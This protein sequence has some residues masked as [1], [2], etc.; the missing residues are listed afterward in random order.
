MLKRS[1]SFI[2]LVSFIMSMMI[3]SGVFFLGAYVLYFSDASVM[4][5]LIA[6]GV[7][8]V[9]S[10]LLALNFVELGMMFPQ[11]GGTY[12]FLK[13]AYSQ[14]LASIFGYTGFL[15]SGSGSIA[16]L[17]LAFASFIRQINPTL[18]TPPTLL[19]SI[20]IIT[21]TGLAMKN[22][23]QNAWVG[24]VITAAKVLGI[25]AVIVAGLSMGDVDVSLTIPQ[26]ESWPSLIS[27]IAFAS[28]ISL[29]AYEG[30]A[31][32]FT[33]GDEIPTHPR[34]LLW[35]IIVGIGGVT[36]LYVLFHLAIYRTVPLLTLLQNLS[37]GNL[38]FAT[39]AMESLFGSNGALF[40]NVLMTIS[41]LGTLHALI[42][43]FPRVYYA[44]AKDGQFFSVAQDINEDA[45]PFKATLL[46]MVMS[47]ILVFTFSLIELTSFVV[48][49]GL[50]YSA[51]VVLGVIVL[52]F[53]QPQTPRPYKVFLYPLTPILSLLVLGYFMYNTYLND[54]RSALIGLLLPLA[55]WLG[56]WYVGHKKKVTNT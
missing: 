55:L 41:I 7:A 45:S 14:R 40:M 25:F 28:I 16:A 10:L 17:A 46:S 39:L 12:V 19:A 5:S 53:R 29:W 49:Q 36:L 23:A 32:I 13:Q 24:L 48:L 26:F 11:S 43:I 9:F 3:G 6:W 56:L 30:W 34:P 31:N 20:I 52:R 42:V 18:T 50:I 47:L 54:S 38:Y 8:G 1:L 15:L 27:M 33:L 37:S 51:L 2:H 44:M 21:L 35:S 4:L 22:I